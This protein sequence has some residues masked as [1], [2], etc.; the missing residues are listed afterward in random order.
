[1]LKTLPRARR[2]LS[3]V[4][5]LEIGRVERFSSPAH[6]ASGAIKRQA[7]LPVAVIPARADFAGR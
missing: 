3:M 4:M 5:T 1:L 6:L 7:Y 2:I